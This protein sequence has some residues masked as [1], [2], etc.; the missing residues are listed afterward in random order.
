MGRP[1]TLMISGAWPPPAPSVWKAWM[2]R[3]LIAATVFSTNP[4]SLS[5]SVWIITC[6]SWSSAT[7]RQQSM[8]AGVVPQSSCSFSEQ[9]PASTISSRAAGSEALPLP[10]RPMFIGKASKD[11]IMR[12]MCHG[13]GVQ[14]VARVPCAGPVPPPSMVVMPLIS[15][16][17]ICCGQMKWICASKPP[18]VSILPSPAMI[19]V[20][21]PMMMVTPS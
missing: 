13:P 11:W 2:V 19:S 16:S 21:G 7:D 17:S 14:V 3:P 6:T 20:P 12:A 4:D 9:A 15:A 8:A 5:V 10:D 1:Q 18:A